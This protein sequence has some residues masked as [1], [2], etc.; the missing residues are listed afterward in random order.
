[1]RNGDITGA[2]KDAGAERDRIAAM[3][4][5]HYSD[6]LKQPPNTFGYGAVKSSAEHF[7]PAT[8]Q[9]TRAFTQSYEQ[10]ARKNRNIPGRD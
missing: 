5:I 8:R 2:H 4:K 9:A 6:M 10:Y 7:E 3:R 1:M